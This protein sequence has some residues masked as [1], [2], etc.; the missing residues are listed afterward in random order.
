MRKRRGI[1]LAAACTAALVALC[2]TIRVDKEPTSQGHSLSYWIRRYNLNTSDRA[3]AQEAIRQIGTNALPYLLRWIEYKP[4]GWRLWLTNARGREFGRGWTWIPLWATTADAGSRAG[5][6][7][8][9]FHALGPTARAAIPRLGDMARDRDPIRQSRGSIALAAIGPPAIPELVA[10]LSDETLSPDAR[11]GATRELRELVYGPII[12]GTLGTNA[13]QAT[14]PLIRNLKDPDEHVAAE[15]AAVLGTLK[16]QPTSA[17][18]ALASALTNSS[19]VV[20]DSAATALGHFSTAAR[21][22]VP[23]LL[24]AMADPDTD[25]RA[26]ASNAVLRIAPEVLTNAPAH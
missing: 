23:A 1:L 24:R 8:V 3:Q 13:D 25:V 10:I 16:L 15:A 20:R 7:M 4:P 18:P 21:S 5:E 12:T 11:F 19:A 9:A 14:M 17:V 2:T 22:V 6:A 26:S